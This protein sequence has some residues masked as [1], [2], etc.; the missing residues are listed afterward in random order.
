[1]GVEA[2][3]QGIRVA[4]DRSVEIP[5][6][7]DQVWALISDWAGMLRWWLPARC[8]AAGRCELMSGQG[9]LMIWLY[10]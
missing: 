3:S 9:S 5:A 7:A 4:L 10:I 2:V 6:P 8:A 1:M